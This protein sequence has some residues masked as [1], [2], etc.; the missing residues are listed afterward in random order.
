MNGQDWVIVDTETNGLTPPIIPVELGA[1][2]MNGWE[3]SG[4]PFRCLLNQNAELSPEASRV[5]GYTRE[6][7]ERDG[8]DPAVAYGAFGSYVGH[9]PIVSYNLA[10]DVDQVLAPEWKRLG[11]GPI[12]RDG[13]CA[14][15][16]AQRLLDPVPAGNC[17]L[18]T[19]RQYYR[20]TERGA[21]TALGDVDTVVDLLQEVLRPI[22]ASRG[23]VTWAQI[24]QLTEAEWFPSRVPFGKHKG[25]LYRDAEQ[26]PDFL[27]WLEWLASSSNPRSSH[28]GRWY[29]DRL[30]AADPEKVSDDARGPFPQPPDADASSDATSGEAGVVPFIDKDLEKLRNLIAF[31][32]ARLAEVQADYTAEKSSADATG[33][34]FFRLVGAH[35]QRRDRLRLTIYYR[36]RY[37]D[38]LLAQG[39]DDTEEVVSEFEEARTQS[40]GD[41]EEAE[42]TASAKL[43]L[44]D[45]EKAEV[46]LLWMK[47]VRVFHP[48]RFAH[49]RERQVIYEQLTA[50]INEA[51]DTG[52]LTILRD[53][54]RDPDGFIA[55]QGWRALYINR[56]DEAED[57]GKLYEAIE[58]QIVERMEAL[59]RLR[60]SPEYELAK[61][62]HA[63]PETLAHMAEEQISALEAEIAQ[64]HREAAQLEAEIAEL[65]GR[66]TGIRS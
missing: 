49:D 54:A 24:R 64:L 23:L 42:R 32:R 57:L 58:I 46:K 44:N 36:R 4:P 28:M 15:R 59:S 65:T 12:G 2:R 10:F 8:E 47:L 30:R 34:A 29:L 33:A 26:D 25:R 51:R 45:D 13:F 40:D 11:L 20:L 18:Q 52:N 7:L 66:Q 50:T 19:L 48:D 37:L 16:L 3:R 60:D 35:H 53:I 22:A 17:K 27:G 63:H 21:H 38:V 62:C 61:L 1:Q 31:A 41:Y 5:H 55:K 6:I 9:R 14:L 43:E 56:D 39:E